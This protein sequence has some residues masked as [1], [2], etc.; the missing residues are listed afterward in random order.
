MAGASAPQAPYRVVQW[1]TGMVGAAAMRSV[2]EHPQMSLVGVYVHSEAKAGRDAGGQGTADLHRTERSAALLVYSRDP[3]PD[4]DLRVDLHEKAVDELRRIYVEYK[5][6]EGYYRE[7]GEH[8]RGAPSQE[9]F[10][11]TLK[12]AS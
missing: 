9:A 2:I 12:K 10:I 3:Y 4:I 6:Y 11:A 1:A 7:R 8:P 5:Q